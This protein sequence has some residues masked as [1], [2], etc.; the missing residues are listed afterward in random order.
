MKL[1]FKKIKTFNSQEYISYRKEIQEFYDILKE[2]KSQY[3][4][5]YYFLLK[6]RK[7]RKPLISLNNN[8]IDKKVDKPISIKNIR[9]RLNRV[10]NGKTNSKKIEKTLGCTIDHLKHC[11]K[12]QFQS[13][14]TWENFGKWYIDLIH[15]CK[16]FHFKNLKPSWKINNLKKV[17][18]I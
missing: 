9:V 11:L 13:G 2:K 16:G 3:D 5:T 14:M 4:K 18:K 17:E 15:S 12:S 1:S 6:E 7:K 10:L 8:L